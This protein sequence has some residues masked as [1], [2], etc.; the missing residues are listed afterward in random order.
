MAATDPDV[1]IGRL[2]IHFK[3]L[4]KQ[5]V[6]E[7]LR[8]KRESGY[9]DIGT[10][11]VEAGFIAPDVLPKLLRAR[12]EYLRRQGGVPMATD[13]LSG[14]VAIVPPSTPPPAASATAAAFGPDADADVPLTPDAPPS[15]GLA[16]DPPA[17]TA[18][19]TAAAAAPE[20][21]GEN[22]GLD[23][24]GVLMNGSSDDASGAVHI[25]GLPERGVEVPEVIAR[26]LHYVPGIRLEKLLGQA[27][28]LGVSDVH[29][30]SGA[31]LRVRRHGQLM[32]AT[33]HNIEDDEAERLIYGLL[34]DDQRRELGEQK[35]LDFAHDIPGVG[36]F[37]GNAYM[38][39]RGL[40]AVLRAIPPEPPTLE[41][42]GMPASLEKLTQYH[43]GMVLFTGPAGCGKSSTMAALVELINQS[44]QDH[45]L[46]IEEPIEFVFKSKKCIVN[47]R[48][49]GSHTASFSRALRAALREDP[50]IIV[51]GELRDLDTISLALSA[52]ETG[53]LVLGSLHTSSAIRTIN[54]LLGVFPPNQQAQIRTMVS[55]SLRAIVSQRLVARADGAGRVPALEI[56]MNTR[57]VG[58]LI[59]DQKTFQITSAMQ[60]GTNL[61]MCQL[62]ASL[63]SLVKQGV[64]TKD[65][66]RKQAEDPKK[67]A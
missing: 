6:A 24:T 17:T 53:H 35:Q 64:I 45:I 19:A 40:D 57:A 7:A 63:A 58:A 61:G 38:Q 42:L 5:Q 22:S 51:I 56:L 18:A 44:R 26:H 43:Q 59:R 30:H 16:V 52:A 20:T 66:A 28:N 3:L 8:R 27:I 13:S 29:V 60:T 62:D 41:S 11:L 39:Q 49:A 9:A 48:Q 33:P 67:F 4:T 46:T 15:G 21:G 36:R 47:Q 14:S 1:L 65:E 37:R 12:D 31:P 2:A 32:P 23:I 55:E 25:E 50:D 10:F 54:R 34:S